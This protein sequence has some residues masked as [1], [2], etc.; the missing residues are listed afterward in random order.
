LPLWNTCYLS[1]PEGFKNEFF[2]VFNGNLIC[3]LILHNIKG[4]CQF[5]FEFEFE[6]N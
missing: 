2:P 5:E 1:H 4:G 6:L 3:K